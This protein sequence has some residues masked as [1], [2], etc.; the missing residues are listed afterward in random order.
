MQ[1]TEEEEEV[2]RVKEVKGV[3]EEEVG[4]VEEEEV[5]G[6]EEVEEEEDAEGGEEEEEEVILLKGCLLDILDF[7]IGMPS[8]GTTSRACAGMGVLLDDRVVEGECNGCLI[9]V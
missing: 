4:G 5:G 7:N 1:V 6:V 9:G 8:W 3:E 2:G